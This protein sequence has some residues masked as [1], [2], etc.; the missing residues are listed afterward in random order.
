MAAPRVLPRLHTV[1]AMRYARYGPPDVLTLEDVEMPVVGENEI[2][3]RVRAASINPLDV[4]FLRGTPYAVRSVTGLSRPRFGGLGTDLAGS[5]EAVGR[6][7]TRFRVGDE[8]FGTGRG[9]LAQY[10]TVKQD[11]AVLRRPAGLSIEH[12]A[13]AP[14]AALTAVQAL[15]DKGRLRPGHRVL[16]NG[17][18]GGVGTFT[19]QIAKAWG[20]QVTGV[21]STRNVALVRSIGADDVIDYTHADFTD[22]GQRYDVVIDTAGGHT[23]SEIRRALTP[24]GVC[25]GVG[26]PLTGNWIAPLL[27][28]ARML[29]YS[30]VIGQT[31]APMLTRQTRDDLVVLRGLLESEQVVP[32]I[33]QTFPLGAAREAVAYVEAGHA[34]GKVVV[35]V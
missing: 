35:T 14:L 1:K 28:P 12:A 25:V 18:S 34:R 19:V 7:V 24:T 10:V 17:A 15:R 5:V 23:L 27:G 22:T 9:T 30:R 8:V 4:R 11:A 3:V 21:C 2:L 31:M 20:A 13:A 32:V 26:G 6:G 29:L 33:D 16:V